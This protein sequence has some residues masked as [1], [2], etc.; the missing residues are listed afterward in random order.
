MHTMNMAKMSTAFTEH[1]NKPAK[2]AKYQLMMPE[3]RWSLIYIGHEINFMGTNWLFIVYAYF[4]PMHPSNTSI[5][6]KATTYLLDEDFLLF[7]N[8]HTLL[9]T[10][11][12]P[13]FP[14]SSKQGVT[15]K[16]SHILTGEPYHSATD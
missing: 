9:L 10:I 2:P 7:G 16:G 11:P 1:K 3:M 14:K 15:S 6:T 5:L 8:P 12:Q 4:K 13:I